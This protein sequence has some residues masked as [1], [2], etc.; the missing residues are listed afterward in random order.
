MSPLDRE[1]GR[2]RLDRALAAAGRGSRREVR[3]LILEGR[4][5]VE[6]DVA[7][8]PGQRVDPETA[9]LEVDG[10]SIQTGRV[11]IMLNKPPGLVTA[12]RDARHPTVFGCLP[13]A[14]RS[15]VVAAGRLDKESEGLLLFT[16]DGALC[17]R[18]IS[19]R[20]EVEKEY[21]V[22]VDGSLEAEFVDRFQRGL[23]LGD[24][25]VCKPAR[26]EI[27]HPAA[28]GM[29]RVILREGKHRQVRRMFAALGREVT[30]LRRIRIGGLRLDPA[31]P[32]GGH[33]RLT[34]GEIATL[35]GPL[36][37]APETA[38]GG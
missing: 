32:P 2:I 1:Q 6:G 29:G 3:R 4:V 21:E 24:G 18:L 5:R 28:P 30:R 31:L 7:T 34:A 20:H 19:P 23:R 17:H 36:G 12:A 38:E 35:L 8:D 10:E 15:R 14:W 33:R 25:Y 9:R 13:E 11:V 26:L 37:A 22:W 27:V 16:D